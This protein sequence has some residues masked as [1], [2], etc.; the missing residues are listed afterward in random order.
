MTLIGVEVDI[1]CRA[2]HQRTAAGSGADPRMSRDDTMTTKN[3]ATSIPAALAQ[4]DSLPD[5]A[6]VRLPIVAAL[7]GIS[8]PTVW[9]WVK[10]GRLPQPSKLGPNTT[11]WRVGDLRRA[12][13]GA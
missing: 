2:A 5:S 13:A 7:N 6:H 3:H 12:L 9:R 4:F 10:T 8:A 1:S 11:G